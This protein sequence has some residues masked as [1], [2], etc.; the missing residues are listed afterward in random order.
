MVIKTKEIKLKI[1]RDSSFGH[2]IISA[3][4]REFSL[5]LTGEDIGS[6][7]KNKKVKVNGKYISN[8]PKKIIKGDFVNILLSRSEIRSFSKEI[9]PEITL[10]EDLIVFEDKY[11]LVANKPTGLSSNATTDSSKDHMLAAIK[12]MR[13]K[14]K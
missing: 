13:P 4:S 14:E 12:R 10:S 5:L 7:I 8:T 6:L 2:Y 1:N 3:L 11:I 9:E